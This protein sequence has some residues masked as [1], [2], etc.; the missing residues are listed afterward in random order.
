[1]SADERSL[2]FTDYISNVTAQRM[3]LITTQQISEYATNR[4][5]SDTSAFLFTN[6]NSNTSTHT[7]SKLITIKSAYCQVP[8]ITTISSTFDT[9]IIKAHID[10]LKSTDCGSYQSTLNDTF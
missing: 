1:L 6:Y 8:I 5:Q 9:S 7:F 3:A 2:K 10:S 4:L